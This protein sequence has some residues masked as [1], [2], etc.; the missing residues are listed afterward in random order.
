MRDKDRRW[1]AIDGEGVGRRPHRYIMLCTSDG[2][3]LEDRGGLGTRECLDLLLSLGSRDARVCGFYL[4]YDWTMI[5]RE[6]PDRSIYL[7]LRPE[8]RSQEDG[9]FTRI[10]WKG[11]HLHWLGGAMRIS[12]P[13]T[14]RRVTVWDLGKYFQCTFVEALKLWKLAPEIQDQIASMKAKR[15]VFKW[16]DRAKIKAYCQSECG[17][18]AQLAAQLE[19]AHKDADLLPRAWHGPGSTASVLLKRHNIC[20]RRGTPPQAVHAAAS[21]AYFGGRAEISM[22]GRLDRPVYGYDIS[23]AYPFHSTSLPCLEH[24]RWELVTR[25]RSLD[26]SDIV[27]ACVFGTIEAS[28]GDWGPLPIR[29][30]N[31]SIIFPLS[32]ASGAW[33]L[34]EW[35]AAR[36]GWQGLKFDRAFALRRVCA[37]KPFSF[38]SQLFDH[39]LRVGKET[40]EGKAIK[41]A[42]NSL[43]GKLAQRLHGKFTSRIWAGMIT[44][45]TRA[46]VLDMITQHKRQSH[47]IMVATDGVFSTER[48]AVPDRV[49]LGGWERTDYPDGMTLARPGIYWTP[50]GKLRARGMGRDT[51]DRALKLLSD[52]IERDLPTVRLPDR[53][54]FGGAK[55]TIYRNAK[56]DAVKRS[57]EYGTWHGMP[58]NLSLSPAPKRVIDWTPPR[59]IDHTISHPFRSGET[60]ATAEFIQILE[61]LHELSL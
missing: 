34:T 10:K 30:R 27:Q 32:N 25:E 52:A 3:S 40:G 46:Q 50:D 16:K 23:S 47:V 31:G 15:N 6:L 17:A 4:S 45:G 33:W 55:V 39:R 26:D 61:S 7:L 58:T 8:L 48:H 1:I 57:K 43:Y 49:T 51:L 29:L 21:L 11:Y 38:V 12:H 60:G 13:K 2:D 41:L 37:C 5:L 18:L 54:I 19:R 9:E 28:R 14:G 56:T 20:D 35:K 24:G 53:T 44:A 36:R 22:Q 59:P 42:L